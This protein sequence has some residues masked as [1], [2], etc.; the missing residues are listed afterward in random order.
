[1]LMRSIT[2]RTEH[3]DHDGNDRLARSWPALL[4]GGLNQGV[5]LAAQSEDPTAMVRLKAGFVQ[6]M[7]S[8]R[9]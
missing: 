4:N 6:L 8:L 7:E 9:R 5:V 3:S 1:M 2:N